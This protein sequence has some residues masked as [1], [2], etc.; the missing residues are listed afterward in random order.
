MKKS[1]DPDELFAEHIIYSHPSI[2]TH[3]KLLFNIMLKHSYVP[4][5]FTS[6]II[7]PIVKDKRGDLTDTSNYRPITLSSV[8]SKIFEYF[9]L[10]KFSSYLTSD[11]L[12]FG[13]KPSTGCNNA[14][15]LLRRV[16]QHFNEN[17]SNVYMASLDASKAFDR[18]NH[19][20]LFSI[21]MQRGLPKYFILVLFNWYSRLTVNVRWNNSFSESL[22][23]LSGVRQGGV[24]SGLLFN[25]Y[26]NDILTTLR[27]K[28]LG[29]HL[30]NMFIGALMY[31]DD[32]ILMSASVVDLQS[33]LDICHSVGCVLGI[34][35]N[36]SKSKCILI[37]PNLTIH[38]SDLL[39]GNSK[40]PWVNE[41]NY[42]GITLTAS[43]S[44][45]IDLT[46]IRKKFFI[47]VNSI[48][49]KCTF[50]NDMV[51]LRLLESQCLPILLYATESLK[52]PIS[53]I[54]ELNAC[55]NSVYRKIFGFHKWES[56]RS[57]IHMLGRLDLIHIINLRSLSFI[58][59]ITDSPHISECTKYYLN[60]VY[61][62]SGECISLFR[63]YN[64]D[65]GMSISKIS[66]MINNDFSLSCDDSNH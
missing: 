9:L 18:V 11:I 49:S 47:S 13:Y 51:K 40:I 5:R 33:M 43:K 15:F 48:L 27:H 12:Q 29:C 20:K 22:N 26:V 34:K 62:I 53:Q 39:I 58:K 63:T 25:V 52:L 42:L 37:G 46:L 2:I 32:L 35:F 44:F 64:C 6:G 59:R 41:L 45:H 7:I 17:S 8:I 28:D 21:L 23:V 10:N 55:W 65:I 4:K 60:N 24:L 61:N 36:S 38:P 54:S 57:L 1:A 3:L 16:I 66:Y 30:R 56:V 31:A 19:F 50:T 14:I